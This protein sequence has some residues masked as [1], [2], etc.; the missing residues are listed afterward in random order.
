MLLE[1]KVQYAAIFIS[2]AALAYNYKGMKP[3][4]PVA[5]FA[6]LYANIWCYLSTYFNWWEFPIRTVPFVQDISVTANV[7][8][9]PIL[10][11]FWVRYSPMSRVKWAFLWTTLLT[12]PEYILER[13]TDTIKYHNSYEWYYSYLLWLIS[14]FI[15]YQFHKWFYNDCKTGHQTH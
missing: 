3:F 2:L 6:S 1:L 10:A 4:I 7:I 15:W 11:M 14:W 12:V 13:Y 9:V 8:V 5:L